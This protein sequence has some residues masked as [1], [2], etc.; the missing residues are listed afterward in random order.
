MCCPFS[1]DK[2]KGFTLIGYFNFCLGKSQLQQSAPA[3]CGG[4]VK[5]RLLGSILK[6]LSSS[7][8]HI[9]R[10]TALVANAYKTLLRHGL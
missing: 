2:C 9:L 4:L 1:R 3:S 6:Y 5:Y 10:T 8:H 7:G